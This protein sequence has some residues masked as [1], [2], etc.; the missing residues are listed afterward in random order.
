MTEELLEQDV[1]TNVSVDTFPFINFEKS[2]L[3]VSR[4]ERPGVVEGRKVMV[5]HQGHDTLD[6][7]DILQ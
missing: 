1:G 4:S 6:G 5:V 2:V 3:V 7:I